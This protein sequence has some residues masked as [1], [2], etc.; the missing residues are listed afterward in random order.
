MQVNGLRRIHI[1]SP[2]DCVW[3]LC[4]AWG[5]QLRQQNSPNQART[6]VLCH[7]NR[8]AVMYSLA[9]H[10]VKTENCAILAHFVVF[11]R[12][13]LL[14]YCHPVICDLLA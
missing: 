11:P 1:V 6:N 13:E 7:R 14:T 2:V 5:G 9:V 4:T 3:T 8:L 12:N 10:N